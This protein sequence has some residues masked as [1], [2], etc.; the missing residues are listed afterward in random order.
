MLIAT[1]KLRL[2]ACI[3][4]LRCKYNA[5]ALMVEILCDKY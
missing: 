4:V 2:F 3:V 1:F 5:I